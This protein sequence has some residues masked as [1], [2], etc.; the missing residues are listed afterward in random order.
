MKFTVL[1]KVGLVE[2]RRRFIPNSPAFLGS[3]LEKVPIGTEL[4]ATF[5]DKRPK[6]TGQQNRLYWMYL[7]DIEAEMG[8]LADDLHELFK[9]KF[10][11]PRWVT[12]FDEEV[13]LPPSSTVL[14]KTEFGEYLDKICA[15]TG[16][17]IP[18][19]GELD[20]HEAD[21]RI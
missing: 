7:G 21:Y 2:G 20:T 5:E 8:N 14:S 4:S 6:R 3:R 16:V 1:G 19:P 15:L 9:R 18:D 11:P 13:C 10:L 12:M 17:P